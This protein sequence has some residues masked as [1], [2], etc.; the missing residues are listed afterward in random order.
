MVVEVRR[1]PASRY[2]RKC[3]Q[4]GRIRET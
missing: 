2:Q 4:I 1:V 3:R